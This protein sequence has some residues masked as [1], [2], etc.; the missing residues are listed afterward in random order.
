[1]PDGILFEASSFFF[2][3]DCWFTP[4]DLVF[5]ATLQQRFCMMV[6]SLQADVMDSAPRAAKLG[7]SA[8]VNQIG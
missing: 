8:V 2:F 5:A 4:F 1:M 6:L 7:N 3:D